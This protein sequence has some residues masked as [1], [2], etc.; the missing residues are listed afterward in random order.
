MPTKE[1]RIIVSEEQLV[2]L[3]LEVKIKAVAH[4]N[5]Y[6]DHKDDPLFKA[7]YK[8]YKKAK[9]KLDEYKFNKRHG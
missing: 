2:K 5:D 6:N 3:P 9:D 7:L 1:Y 8:A 4:L